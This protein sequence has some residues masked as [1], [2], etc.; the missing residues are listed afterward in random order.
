M[1]RI[2]LLGLDFGLPI[3]KINFSKYYLIFEK[4]FLQL[5]NFNVYQCIPNVQQAF[6]SLLKT[7][8]HKHFSDFKPMNDFFSIFTKSDLSI[9]K[10]LSSDKN[11]YITKPDK[12]CGVVLLNTVDYEQKVYDI[13]NDSEKIE[14]IHAEEKNYL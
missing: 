10:R 11:L 14:E 13:I 5:Q 1:K 9:L 12:G 6:R 8:A 7:I 2:L 3:K 4:L